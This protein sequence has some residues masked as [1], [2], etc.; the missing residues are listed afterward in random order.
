MASAKIAITISEVVLQRLDTLVQQGR[1]PNRSRA[2]Q[3]AVEEKV[4][5]YERNRLAEALALLDV[6]KEAAE[7]EDGMAI[8][9]DRWPTY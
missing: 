5:H 3:A 9:L 7:A 6:T 4:S 1:Y 2:I 8:E